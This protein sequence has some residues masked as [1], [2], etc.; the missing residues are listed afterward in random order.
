MKREPQNSASCDIPV[1]MN[2]ASVN[3]MAA[4][5]S[6][7]TTSASREA[8]RADG[9]QERRPGGLDGKKCRADKEKVGRQPLWRVGVKG[10]AEACH[11]AFKELQRDEEEAD[12]RADAEYESR[13]QGVLH[14][15]MRA[16]PPVDERSAG[17][18]REPAQRRHEVGAPP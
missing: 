8:L 14:H 1:C 11:H 13:W 4:S 16:E 2:W 6:A 17:G 12:E 5:P 7:V 3:C 10:A 18:D 9:P 15:A